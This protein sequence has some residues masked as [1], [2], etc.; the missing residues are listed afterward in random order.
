MIL[1]GGSFS[2]TAPQGLSIRNAG[3]Y[4]EQCNDITW[5]NGDNSISGESG[6]HLSFKT[7]N[8]SSN[9]EKLQIS[10]GSGN[11]GNWLKTSQSGALFAYD[12]KS[13][14]SST[15]RPA[16]GDWVYFGDFGY[17]A[18]KHGKFVVEWS[19]ISSPGCCH[20][21]YVILEAG[22]SYGP[23]YDYDWSESLK[24]LHYDAH[25][26]DHFKAW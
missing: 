11:A 1:N 19:N 25:N 5:N 3:I 14:N 9:T 15:C 2:E 6:Y 22:T 13:N 24:V 21:G 4:L 16:N 7:Y 8:G 20:H 10:G 26:S 23:G 18:N 12:V 17:G